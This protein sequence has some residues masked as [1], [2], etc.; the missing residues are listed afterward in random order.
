MNEEKKKELL[1]KIENA[2]DMEELRSLQEELNSLKEE[3]KKA[4]EEKAKLE[5]ERALLRKDAEGIEVKDNNTEDR[6]KKN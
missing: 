2:K 1:A 4:E 5:E 6:S 3:E